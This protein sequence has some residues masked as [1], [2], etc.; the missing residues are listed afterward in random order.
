MATVGSTTGVVTG[1]SAG[2]TV[3][4]YTLASGCGR[5]TTVTVNPVPADITGSGPLCIG[6]TTTFG[7]TTPG[8]TWLSSNS[9]IATVGSLTGLVTGVSAGTATITYSISSTTCFKTRTVTILTTPG[10]I[11]GSSNICVG[12]VTTFTNGTA[13]GNWTSTATGVATVGL[14]TGTV[15]GIAPGTTVISYT[16]GNGCG[17]ALPLTVNLTPAPITGPTRVCIGAT[18]TLSTTTGGGTWSSSNSGVSSI[19]STTGIVTGVTAGSATITYSLAAGCFVTYADTVF[20][21]PAA[22]TPPG[23]VAICVGATT[24]LGDASPG[25]TWTS[26]NTGFA[27]VGASTG[28]VTGVGA[29]VVT[30]S[31]TNAAGCAALKTVTVNTTPVATTPSSASIC[32]GNS[33]TFSNAT[34]GGLWS[35]SNGAIATV[36]SVSGVVT[37]V[38]AGSATISYSIGSCSALATVTVNANPAAITPGGSVTICVGTTTTLGNVSAGTWSSGN[39]AIAT[40]GSVSGIVTGVSAGNATISYIN[41]AGCFAIKSVTVAPTPT[42]ISPSSS[43]LCQGATLAMTNGTT[44]GNWTSSNTGVA[45]VGATTGV[46]SGVATGS[47]TISYTIG[48]CSALATVTVNA[49]PAAITPSG[50][51]AI[52]V[53]ATTT[54]SDASPGGTWSSGNTALATVGSVSGVVTGAGAGSVTIFYTNAA[55]CTAAKT[56]T[57]N[58]TPAAISPSSISICNGNS[59]TLTD[60]TSG[61]VWSSSNTGIATVGSATGTVT[62]VAVG[63]ATVSYT[64]GGCSALANV[65]ISALANAGIITGTPNICVGST[66]T[67]VDGSPG[68]RWSSSLPGIATVGSSSGVVTAIAAGTAVISYTVTNGCGSAS[69]TYTV[70]SV[71][72]GVA[73]I[74]GTSLICAGTTTTYTNATPGGVWVSRNPALATIVSGTGF[75]TAISSGLDTIT[76]SVTNVCGT[77]VA[78]KTV[79]IGAFL[80]AGTILGSSSVCEG[81]TITLTDGA[82]G[83]TWSASNANATVVGG[84]VTGVT[85]GVDTIMYTTTSTCGSAV[86]TKTITINPAPN[87]GTISG[88]SLVCAGVTSLY[89]NT[90]TGGTWSVTNSRATINSLGLLTTITPGV[91]TIRYTHT[92]SCGTAVASK[93]VTIG[94]YITAGTI[95]GASSVCVGTTITLSNGTTGGAWSSSNTTA[96]IG[97]GTGIVTGVS[98]G[99]DTISYTVSSSCGSVSTTKTITVNPQP[100][101]GNIVGPSVLCVGSTSTFTNAV[102]GG[103]WSMTNSRATISSGGVATP[104]TNG[105]DTI[106]YR[107]TNVCGTAR[108]TQIVTINTAPTA[109]TISGASTVCIGIPV[110]LSHGTPGGVWSSSST[111]AAVTS[112][113]VVWGVTVGTAVISYTITN[114]CGTAVAT[115]TMTINPA[116][117]PGTISG[118]SGICTGATYTYTNTVTTGTWSMTNAL[119][120]VSSGGV[121]TPLAAGIDTIV[122]T[123]SSGCGTATAMKTLTINLAPNAGAISGPSALCIGTPITLINPATGGVWSSSNSTATVVGGVVS[124][125]STGLDTIYYTVTNSCGTAVASKTVAINAFPTSGVILGPNSVCATS[126]TIYTDSIPG[127]SWS[128]TNTTLATITSAGVLTAIAPGT[129]TILYTVTNTCG[130]VVASK[131]ITI[132]ASLSAGTITGPGG[133]CAGSNITLSNA[134]GGGVWSSSNTAVASIG[135]STGIVTGVG[136]GTA[137]I[138]YAVTG[139]CGT[140]YD[141]AIVSVGA[142]P[143]VGAITGPSSVC[144]SSLIFLTNSVPGGVWSSRIGNA[145]ITTA[146]VVTGITSGLDT[147]YYT[148]TNACGTAAAIK[149]ITIN[150]L[151]TMSAIAGPVSLCIGSPITYTNP[152]S[153]GLWSSSNTA[154]A[155]IGSISG[156]ATGITS[157]VAVLSYTI[158]NGCGTAQ[159]TTTVAVNALPTSGTIIGPASVCLGSTITLSNATPGGTWTTRT[160]NVTVTSAGIVTG[161]TLGLD[162]VNYTVSNACGSA[163]SIKII[164]VNPVPG[165]GTISG[166]ASVC[167][168]SSVTLTHPAPGGVWSSSSPAIARIG[169]TTGIVTGVSAGVAVLS[170]SITTT[171]GSTL[172]TTTI[173]VNPLANSGTIIGPANVCVGSVILLSDAAPGGTWSTRTGNVSI[174]SFGLVTGL[175]AGTDTVNYTVSNSCGTAVSIKVLTINPAPTAGVVSGPASICIG[176]SDTMRSTVSGGIWSRSNFNASVGSLSGIVSGVAAG[177]VNITYSVTNACGTVS[178][179]ATVIVNPLTSAGTI[180]GLDSVCTTSSITLANAIPGGTWSA[181][182]GN[183]IV[184]GG[185]VIGVSEGT[186]PISY[187]VTGA[188]GT[189]V[190]VKVIHILT[191]PYAGFI[192]GGPG[193]CLGSSI[194]MSAT[195]PGGVWSSVFGNAVVTAPGVVYGATLGEDTIHYIITN[196]CGVSSTSK[197]VTIN[198]LPVTEP[199]TGATKQCLGSTITLS[200]TIPGGLW[201]SSDVLIANVGSTSGVV[202]GVFPGTA[203]IAYTIEN[204]YGCRA[205]STIVDTVTTIPVVPA[206]MGGN[207]VCLGSAITLTD[208]LTGG[209]WTTSDAT[210]ASVD[211]TTGVVSGVALGTATITYSVATSCGIYGVTNTVTVNPLTTLPAIVGPTRICVGANATLINPTSGG[212][213]S[214]GDSAIAIVGSTSGIVTGVAA[215]VVNITF[216]YT[217]GFGCT[218]STTQTDTVVA[219]P[220]V[221]P[222][223][224]ITHQCFGTSTTLSNTTP[225]GVWSSSDLL[226]ATVG[227]TT[228]IVT[229]VFPGVAT[230]AYFVT[231]SDGCTNAAITLDTVG[232]LPTLSGIGGITHQCIGTDITL[233]NDTLGGV[234]SSSDTTIAFVNALTGVVTGRTAGIATI[235]YTLVSPTGCAGTVTVSDTVY[236]PTTLPAI[237]GIARQ[238]VG[239][240]SVLVNDTL[241]GR[242]LSGDT[243]IA[244]IGVSTGI[245]TGVTPG[246]V[247]IYYFYTNVHGCNSTTMISDTVNAYPSVAPITGVA[248][249]CMGTSTTLSDSTTGGVWSSSDVIVASVGSATG[250]VT[251]VFPGMATISYSVTANGCTTVAT[252]ADT[253]RTLPMPSPITGATNVCI[254]ATTTLHNADSTGIWS[255]DNVLI[256]T[257]GSTSGVVSG[258]TAGFATIYYTVTNEC[259]F[260]VDTAIV[261][262]NPIPVAGTISATATSLCAGNTIT[263]TPSVTGGVWYSADT[264]I[265]KVDT[266]GVVTGMATGAVTIY[267]SVTSSAGCVGVTSI[268]LFIGTAIPP[269]SIT[270]GGSATLCHG[271]PV[272]LSVDTVAAGITY[273]WLY[274]GAVIP[275]AT[276]SAYTTLTSGDFAVVV[277][278]GI[279]T[280]TL[281]RTVVV[282][283]PDPVITF[284]LPDMLS[285]GAYSYYQ[286]YRNGVALV[287]DTTQIIHVSTGGNYTVEVRD[288]N[289]CSDTSSI[290]IVSDNVGNGVTDVNVAAAINVFPNPATAV[291]N[292]QSPVL[293]NVKVLSMDGKVLI[294]QPNAR[295]IDVSSLVNGLYMVAIYDQNDMLIKTTRFAK[296]E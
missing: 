25:G 27:T 190:A 58:V 188:C 78:S 112:A 221:D 263:L 90:A 56:I 206:I 128:V 191:S 43:P 194:T 255:S 207:N 77:S 18:I 89:T 209:T 179:F 291:L 139:S 192:T 208:T 223:T 68:G 98:A 82:P 36:G 173:A 19:G 130:T 253:V 215:G 41:A 79:T 270:P 245:A 182:N 170:Y 159:S 95:T 243:T 185:L 127:G 116:L 85:A 60:A 213:W 131:I 87:A 237:T 178:S 9:G 244:T 71:P 167:A 54:L 140:V 103:T 69:A 265:A 163:T 121:V 26:D 205:T 48:S 260:I 17:V 3:V 113:G 186:T 107:V 34:G 249:Q 67:F 24:T 246:I 273:Q 264:T 64:I 240:T 88:S 184:S 183:A 38:S 12:T 100:D 122:Y 108:D 80:T 23:A 292:I 157:G 37:G 62:G 285:T 238:C 160:G 162:T 106:I 119:A 175:T 120:T 284:T 30:I 187:T 32:A 15:T 96:T 49:N 126:F 31:Y 226:V 152:T 217:N 2:T 295:S 236:A 222:I 202:T 261:T 231:N 123:V 50:A 242:W 279:C 228:G 8:G 288:A 72:T 91:D 165:T 129:D 84:V 156:L 13:G 141:T 286:W 59:S 251:G 200:N 267:Y 287:G 204:I 111:A 110:T 35:S 52:C 93:T 250:V 262:V 155:T 97:T 101:A 124:G 22:I 212:T 4:S 290:Y 149:E 283:P 63:T 86:A 293:V 220:V 203:T 177:S 14:T 153:G 114:S 227:S 196:L 135:S 147:I 193:I 161:L 269:I 109:G 296:S 174:T 256:A 29:G 198:P 1:I 138:T 16:L 51:V 259:G 143:A 144:V 289:G 136:A 233:T 20:A 146:G 197:V 171:C 232:I 275:G 61:G 210:I 211:A 230:I 229:G 45:T 216:S 235:S 268:N 195:N 40:I 166:P 219:L 44:G 176:G 282:G 74:V 272:T 33:T 83:G 148:L 55:G 7:N 39:T 154:V 281:T 241:G 99:V 181:G 266:A 234:W 75:F 28:V 94:A 92:N 224:G 199:I 53:G 201:S 70:T 11:T 133:L 225:G 214:T 168:G 6:A 254:G 57:V 150:G 137:F 257:V 81:A 180:T 158:T 274:N 47:A 218:S 248:R 151:P 102:S 118:T 169:S 276:S 164:T 142:L 115:K 65:T 125:V 258:L 76:Y 134:T 189:A 252:I 105:L 239:A 46:V 42:A 271:N 73:T 247:D 278:N 172:A 10:A 280:R 277:S 117:D 5:A 145:T 294:S 21:N 66:S 104:V 132:G